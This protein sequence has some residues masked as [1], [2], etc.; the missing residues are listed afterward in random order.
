[1]A[2]VTKTFTENEASNYK[3]T[4]TLKLTGSDL[5]VTAAN[6]S[7]K[8]G[9]YPTLVAKYVYSGKSYGLIFVHGIMYARYDTSNYRLGFFSKEKM[10]ESGYKVKMTSGTEYTIS[11][12][13]GTSGADSPVLNTVPASRFFDSNNPTVSS[14]PIIARTY[15]SDMAMVLPLYMESGTKQQADQNNSTEKWNGYPKS[16]NTNVYWGQIGT[17]YYKVKPAINS[18][19]ISKNTPGGYYAGKTTITALVSAT[20]YYG[21]NIDSVKLTVGNQNATRSGAGQVSLLLDATGT[22]TPTITVI[23]SRGQIQTKTDLPQ[24][25]VGPYNAPSAVLNVERADASG[26]SSNSGLYGLLIA[27]ITYTNGAGKLNK[28]YVYKDG[29]DISSS[30]TWYTSRG[31]NGTVANPVSSW[32]DYNPTSPVRLYG[33]TTDMFSPDQAYTIGLRPRD[34]YQSGNTVEK[35]LPSEFYPLDLF[36]GGQ[37]VA[38]GQMAVRNGFDVN[39]DT[40]F[41]KDVYF[42]NNKVSD[43]VFG[44]TVGGAGQN[45]HTVTNTACI[46]R[47]FIVATC[48][49]IACAVTYAQFTNHVSST[50]V[51]SADGAMKFYFDRT[52]SA[53]TRINY[54]CW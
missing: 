6:Q 1:M 3:A 11:N 16:E 33:L 34:V 9:S 15:H 18:V 19:D 20:A 52:L 24:I 8:L 48:M 17:I 27:D 37:G 40:H 30:V 13:T 22:F 41:F 49:D 5:N 44:S 47:S 51:R 31:N 10:S 45:Y 46:G 7:L 43:M 54:I 4:W 29:T 53:N 36:A 42:G 39:M 12:E 35:Q 50:D 23:D 32:T 2:T 28:P 21:G 25:T 14:I 26:A 38:L